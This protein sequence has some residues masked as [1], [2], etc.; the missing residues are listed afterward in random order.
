[1]PKIGVK[2]QPVQSNLSEPYWQTTDGKTV[3][4]YLGDVIDRLR[5]LPDESVQLIVTSPPYWGLRDY[6][7]ADWKG[8]DVA[9]DHKRP[10]QSPN[11]RRVDS[12]GKIGNNNTN[13]DH[14]HETGYA[15]IC[16]KCGA[17]CIDRQLGSEELP[18]CSIGG[19]AKCG[20]CHVCRMVAVFREARRVLRDDG[21]LFLNY[22][23][24]YGGYGETRS[25]ADDLDGAFARDGGQSSN[26]GTAQSPKVKS[27][28]KSGNLVGVPWRVAF[29]LQADG[30]ILRSDIPWV[31]RSPMPESCKNRPAKSLEYV[32]MFVKKMGYF[33]DDVAIRKPATPAER[34][35]SGKSGSAGQAI[36]AGV[37][38]SGNGKPGS[39]MRTGSTRNYWNNDLWFE[40]IREPWGVVHVNDEIVGVDQTSSGYLGA[41]FA[42]YGPRL[43]AP[44]ILAGTSAKGCCGECGTPWRRVTVDHSPRGYHGGGKGSGGNRNDDNRGSAN[45]KAIGNTCSNTVAGV[46]VKTVGWEPNCECNGKF[47]KK[48]VKVVGQAVNNGI[49]PNGPAVGAVDHSP[50]GY[51]VEGVAVEDK[52][53]QRQRAKSLETKE[54]FV[55]VREYIPSIPLEDHPL[56][57]CTVLDPF[58][59][60]GT[61]AAVC[62]DLGRYAVGIDLSKK[63]LDVN[64]IPRIEGVFLSR[65]ALSHLVRRKERKVVMVGQKTEV[66]MGLTT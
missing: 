30:W 20:E 54:R 52:A 35:I 48:R 65:P 19:T 34:V 12:R 46:E 47:V 60:S 49:I 50:R 24:T 37:K 45:P 64:A 66:R 31:K 55:T 27:G 4:L 53:E 18:D 10:S 36:G 29:G 38:P 23:D 2:V 43:I 1:M 6:G 16:G 14:R 42:T 39:V 5:D 8:G 17:T 15:K 61:T 40:S 59:G 44:F 25:E 57:P 22:G 63:Y 9:C 3:R 11:L 41:H 13:W 58:M 62:I 26:D 56:I 21:V 28:L 51:A 33:Y 32:F 7:T